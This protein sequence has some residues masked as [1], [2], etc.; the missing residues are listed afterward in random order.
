MD[1]DDVL[2]V[3]LSFFFLLSLLSLFNKKTNKEFQLIH[4]F[5]DKTKAN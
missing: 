1:V 4:K 2:C 5:I 3:F